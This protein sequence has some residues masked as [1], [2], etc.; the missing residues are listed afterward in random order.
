[1]YVV[2]W[3]SSSRFVGSDYDYSVGSD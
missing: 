1:V 3:V 2:I